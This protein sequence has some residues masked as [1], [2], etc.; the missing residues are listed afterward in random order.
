MSGAAIGFLRKTLTR[1]DLAVIIL[2]SIGTLLSFSLWSTREA[3]H[4]AVIVVDGQETGTFSLDAGHTTMR[5]EGAEG[6][7]SIEIKDGRVRM[8]DSTCPGKYCVKTG[9]IGR[10]GQMVCCVPNRV[11]IKIID[12]T[13]AY[14]ALAR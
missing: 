3:G 9:W 14:D 8:K 12:G 11:I 4:R 1:A 5:F 7:F 13:E 10:E 2:F 6:P